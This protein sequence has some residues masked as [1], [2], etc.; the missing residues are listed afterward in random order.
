M[1]AT[2][3]LPEVSFHD[4]STHVFYQPRHGAVTLYGYGIKV[5]VDRGHLTFEDATMYSS[6]V[7][8]L[9]KTFQRG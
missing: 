3:T 1:A 4:N 2:Q 6:D 9:K 8:D 5:S 7:E